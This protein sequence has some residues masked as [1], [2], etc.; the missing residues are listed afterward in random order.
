VEIKTLLLPREAILTTNQ[1]DRIA[2]ILDN[3]G[4]VGLGIII[5]EPIFINHS[6][7][8]FIIISGCIAV[9]GVWL[10]SIAIAK[11]G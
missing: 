2:N 8:I 7:N 10:V 3:A 9:V 6:I 4:Q 11:R 5:L 1:L